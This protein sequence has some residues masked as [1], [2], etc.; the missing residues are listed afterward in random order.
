MPAFTARCSSQP[1][2]RRD[3]Q[4]SPVIL[5]ADDALQRFAKGVWGSAPGLDPGFGRAFGSSNAPV[6]LTTL[7]RAGTNTLRHV[8]EWDDNLKLRGPH[9]NRPG[10]MY[11]DAATLTKGSREWQAMQSIAVLQRAFGLG[12]DGPIRDVVSF[13]VLAAVDM[14]ISQPSYDRFE[15]A[16]VEAA[17]D[18]ARHGPFDAVSRL[19]AELA[20]SAPSTT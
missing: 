15:A 19:E 16:V 12:K 17:R 8:S 6:Q 13:R 4:A 20:R 5:T 10:E 9:L 3:H 1:R 7:L 18:I 2:I 11:P 14:D